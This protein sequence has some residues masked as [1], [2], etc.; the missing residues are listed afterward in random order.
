MK[1]SNILLPDRIN[2]RNLIE[3]SVKKTQNIGR[4][5][6]VKPTPLR[7]LDIKRDYELILRY[8][9]LF[10]WGIYININNIDTLCT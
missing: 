7:D 8:L 1:I 3:Q 10:Y 5:L 6:D 2:Q 4:S 9:Y